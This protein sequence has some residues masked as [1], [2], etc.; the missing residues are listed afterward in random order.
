LQTGKLTENGHAGFANALEESFPAF[1]WSSFSVQDEHGFILKNKL[2]THN[3]VQREVIDL[4]DQAAQFQVVS[5]QS[6]WK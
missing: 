6:P 5:G 2:L 1:P 4:F 3:G